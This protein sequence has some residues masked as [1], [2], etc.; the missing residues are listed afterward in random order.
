[1]PAPF[2]RSGYGTVAGLESLCQEKVRAAWA[3]RARP[4]GTVIGMAGNI[5]PE[6]AREALRRSGNVL[7]PGGDPSPL[8]FPGPPVVLPRS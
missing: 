8:S 3:R 4:G 6:R 1:M 2:N 7:V 5:E